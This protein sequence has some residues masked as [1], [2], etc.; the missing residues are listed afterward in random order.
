MSERESGETA[1]YSGI[2]HLGDD[3]EIPCG[4][5]DDGTRL[6][7]ERAVTKALGGKRGGSHCCARKKVANCPSTP[8]PT[9]CNPTSPR[10]WE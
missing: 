4:V 7:S 10:P 6:L 8:R 1:R 5:M 3:I 9:T 2:L